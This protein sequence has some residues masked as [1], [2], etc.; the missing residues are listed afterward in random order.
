MEKANI[1]EYLIVQGASPYIKDQ[2]GQRVIESKLFQ[3]DIKQ[4]LKNHKPDPSKKTYS[5]YLAGPEVFLTFNQAA[6]QFIKAQTRLF[7]SYHLQS[8]LYNIEGLYPFDSGYTPKNMDFQDGVKIYEGDV[9][10]MNQSQAVMA[11]MV[12]FRGP[13]MDGGTAYEMGYMT[14]QGKV[15]VGYYDEKPYFDNYQM[16]RPYTQKVTEDMGEL[17]KKGPYNLTY[18]KDNF[19]VEPFQMPDNL[20]MLVPTLNS[21]GKLNIASSSWEALFCLKEKLDAHQKSSK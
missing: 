6:G 14:A 4:I 3:S 20:M 15:I 21:A 8:A 18:D 19:L 11:N 2:K 13:G 7:N 10:L 12:K 5:V 16:N 17:T 9:N 1:I